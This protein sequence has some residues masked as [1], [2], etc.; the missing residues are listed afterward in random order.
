MPKKILDGTVISDKGNKSI[1]VI[2]E[3]KYQHPV[4]HKVIKTKKKYHVHDE[5]NS[6]CDKCSIISAASA[7]C[8][9]RN[10]LFIN[11]ASLIDIFSLITFIYSLLNSKLTILSLLFLIKLMIDIS[12]FFERYPYIT[13]LI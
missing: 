1:T 11:V 4:L 3:R 2:V 6:S 9:S 10:E 7:G 12:S 13:I 5:N 8:I